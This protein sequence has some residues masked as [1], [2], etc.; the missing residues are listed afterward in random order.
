MCLYT[1][2]VCLCRFQ[3]WVHLHGVMWQK[4]WLE[5]NSD[6]QQLVKQWPSP[7]GGNAGVQGQDPNVQ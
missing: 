6:W 4:W 5:Q 1:F 7:M 3:P 2:G